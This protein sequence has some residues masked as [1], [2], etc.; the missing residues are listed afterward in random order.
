[1]SYGA[2]AGAAAA[3]AAAARAIKASGAIVQVEPAA[4]ESILARTD[5]PLVVT[6]PGGFLGR[7]H[8]YLTAYRGLLFYTISVNPLRLDSR[9]ELMTA[10]KI[11]TPD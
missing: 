9:C 3:A 10:G 11:W 8:K 6:A 7:K 1:M 4:F 2:A 5:S